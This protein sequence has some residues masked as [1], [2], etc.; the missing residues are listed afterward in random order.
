MSTTSLKI[1]TKK[2]EDKSLEAYV[3][4]FGIFLDEITHVLEMKKVMGDG[5]VL[6]SLQKNPCDAQ[7]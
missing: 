2:R 1:E 7:T 5:K 6:L 3:Q 4:C